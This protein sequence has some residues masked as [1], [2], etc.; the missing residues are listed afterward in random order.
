VITGNYVM[1]LPSD[2]ARSR[3]TG[4][5]GERGRPGS[6][7]GLIDRPKEKITLACINLRAPQFKMSYLCSCV[8]DV[9]HTRTE[10]LAQSVAIE[11]LPPNRLL[12]LTLSGT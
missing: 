5:I 11:I 9:Y 2:Q 7:P 10:W 3:M 12:S 4:R 8:N 1:L 6:P